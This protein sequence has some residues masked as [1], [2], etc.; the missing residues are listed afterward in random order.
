MD[1]VIE[2]TMMWSGSYE[3]KWKY[4]DHAETIV[5][6]WLAKKNQLIFEDQSHGNMPEW[7]LLL[8]GQKYEVKFKSDT[9]LN[10]EY[11]NAAGEM[12]GIMATHSKYYIM[13]NAGWGKHNGDMI[14]VGKVRL[15][16]TKFI[17]KIVVNKLM[18][19]DKHIITY[20]AGPN[21][22]GAKMIRLDSK[23]DF[24]NNSDGWICDIP[25]SKSATG[26]VQYHFKNVPNVRPL[27]QRPVD[28]LVVM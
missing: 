2:P 3:D 22:P 27:K 9:D 19:G 11:A 13:I 15:L 18:D 1:Y 4:T 14:Q 16:E 5:G 28:S 25:Y 26:N 10:I 21:G 17:K 20:P 23:L 6:N 8:S 7:D 24:P 12:T